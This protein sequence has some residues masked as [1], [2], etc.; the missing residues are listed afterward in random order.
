[1]KKNV[2]SETQKGNACFLT[3]QYSQANA[4]YYNALLEAGALKIVVRYVQKNKDNLQE[5]QDKLHELLKQ[6]YQITLFPGALPIFLISIQ[7][8]LDVIEDERAR[9]RLKEKILSKHPKT[10]E[11]YVDALLEYSE[12]PSWQEIGFVS[13][14]L[15]EQGFNYYDCDVDR[16]CH[17]R[18][19]AQ[20]LT[21]FEQSLGEKKP[22]SIS[23]IDAMT[24]HEFED[25]LEEY[26]LKTGYLVEKRKRSHEQGLDLLIERH[27]ERIAVQA[28]RRSKPV[29]NKAVQEALAARH[30]YSLTRALVVTNSYFTLS[31][32]Q[33]AERSKV[34]LWDRETLKEKIKKIL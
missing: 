12:N 8:Q 29:S 28:K 31:A 20:D 21:R 3:R 9:E 32:Q 17:D 13:Q 6:K 30:F 18:Q 34:E 23:D 27:G 10:P 11:Q 33:L 14:M 5:D 4:H 15:Q 26:F 2:A 16:L 19:R 22:I 1:M 25:F 7:K 24:G